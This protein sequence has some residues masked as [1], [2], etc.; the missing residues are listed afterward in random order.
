MEL[1]KILGA[2]IS[3][4]IFVFPLILYMMGEISIVAPLVNILV[5]ILIPISM[6]IG[7][8]TVALSYISINLSL[9]PAFLNYLILNYDLKIVDFFADFEFSTLSFKDFN[10]TYMIT[11][12]FVYILIFLFY[13]RYKNK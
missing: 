11:I 4:Q 1:K 2:T 13:R 5:L 10:L 6:V 9:L 3:T 7:I 12:Y 8:L